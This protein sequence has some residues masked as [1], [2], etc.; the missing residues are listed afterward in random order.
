MTKAEYLS[1]IR[2]RINGISTEDVEKNIEY[3]SEM[4]DDRIEE[5]MT[6]EEAVSQ[7][8]S[9]R[10]AADM[11]LAETP[12]TKLVEDKINS[13]KQFRTW[14][15]VLIA[16]GAP[17]WLALLIAAISVILALV[18]SVFAILISFY[19]VGFAIGVTAIAGIA[20]AVMFAVTLNMKAAMFM[21]GSGLICAGLL[22]LFIMIVK[23]A[24]V[25]VVRL[26][27]WFG[28]IIK[29]MFAGR[30]KTDRE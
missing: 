12:I 20:G 5:G 24:T 17:L 13:K 2:E 15:I 19:A 14:E 21:L 6:E 11:I 4:I 23:P 29:R 1:Q 10:K 3:Y 27:A 9:P 18:I 26:C 30:N 22:I 8:D 7:M 16:L 28:K 25:G